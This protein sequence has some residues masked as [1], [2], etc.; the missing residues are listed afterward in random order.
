MMTVHIKLFAILRDLAGMRETKLNLSDGITVADAVQQLVAQHP[1]ISRYV[2][3]LAYAVN[4]QYAP[5]STE[6][7]DGDELAL[8]PPVSGG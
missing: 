1:Q 3:K 2:A 7:H 4:E 8:I 6:L 5:I